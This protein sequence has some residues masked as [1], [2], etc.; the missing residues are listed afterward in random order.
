MKCQYCNSN[1]ATLRTSECRGYL[2]STCAN[3]RP[4][5]G[6]GQGCML[7]MDSF[8]MPVTIQPSRKSILMRR[9]AAQS[10]QSPDVKNVKDEDDDD[11]DKKSP[12]LSVSDDIEQMYSP[13][14][15]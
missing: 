15:Q 3:D 12:V 6:C 10:K 1:T 8:C 5:A 4:D 14:K 9:A 7:C 13:L 2:C 11:N